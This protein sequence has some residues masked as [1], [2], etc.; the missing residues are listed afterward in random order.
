MNANTAQLRDRLTGALI[1]LARATDG[2][3]H[4]ISDS[5]TAVVVESLSATLT[6]ANSD[7]ATLTSL[8]HR[9]EEE[10][11][12]MVPNCFSCTSPCGRTSEYDMQKLQKAPQDV[13]RL[14]FQ[15]LQG[16]RDM[17]LHVRRAA[18]LG[19]HD[20]AVDDFFYKALIVIGMDEFGAEEL[21]PIL[22]E[23]KAVNLKCTTLSDSCE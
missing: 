10:K 4:L 16:I 22:E 1:G 2:N 8:L 20:K 3:E 6:G 15:L 7:H 12:K 18:A 23:W 13:Q 17:A 19:L 21:L 5:S 9:V 11:Q 14:K